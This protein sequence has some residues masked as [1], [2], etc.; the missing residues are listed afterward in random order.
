M[1]LIPLTFSKTK[2]LGSKSSTSLAYASNNTFLGSA[3]FLSPIT[4]KP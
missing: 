1:D 2:H 4:E 3:E